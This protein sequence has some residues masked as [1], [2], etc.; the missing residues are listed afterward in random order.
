MPHLFIEHS[1]NVEDQVDI[2]AVVDAL[3]DAAL[4]TGTAAIDALRTRAIR[5]DVVAIADRHPDNAFVAVI[6]RIGAGRDDAEKRSLAEALMR[7]LDDVLGSAQASMMLSVEV[8]E[9]EP[10]F[11]LNKNNLRAGVER[12]ANLI[13]KPGAC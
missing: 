7:A 2:A 1:A 8:Q 12:R 4:A 13:S 3:H 11:R 5:R 10:A 9:I 6:I